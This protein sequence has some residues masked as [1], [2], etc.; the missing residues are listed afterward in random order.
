LLLLG[1]L[2]MYVERWVLKWETD[3]RLNRQLYM[4]CRW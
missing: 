4:F 3:I 1:K 2:S